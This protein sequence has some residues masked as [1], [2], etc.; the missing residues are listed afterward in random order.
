MDAP[1]FGS[2]AP[3]P[4]PAPQANN[5]GMNAMLLNYLLRMSGQPLNDQASAADQAQKQNQ[6]RSDRNAT[7]I[8][9]FTA[10]NLDQNAMQPDEMQNYNF[11]KQIG[12]IPERT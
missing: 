3:P 4:L 5:S 11:L 2:F 1:P 10:P 12:L 6:M 9:T 7:S 8:P